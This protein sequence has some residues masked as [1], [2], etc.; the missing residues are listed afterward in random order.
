MISFDILRFLRHVWYS[1]TGKN[2]HVVCNAR[3]VLFNI[4]A[5]TGHFLFQIAARVSFVL[6]WILFFNFRK[7][8][9]QKPV[10]IVGNFRSGSSFLQRLM[11]LDRTNFTS[12]STWEIYF[13]PALLQK[14]FYK[15]VFT[16][17]RIIGSP[18]R[19]LISVIE[20]RSLGTVR[21]HKMGFAEPEEDEGVFAYTWDCLFLWLMFPYM[22]DVPPLHRFD[23][24]LPESKKRALMRFYERCV[25][26]HMLFRKTSRH[27]LSKSPAF[28]PKVQSLLK[29]F[30]DARFIYLVRTP[31]EVIP[32]I[33]NW[34]TLAWN[35]FVNPDERYPYREFVIEMTRHWYSYTVDFLKTLPEDQHI[36]MLYEDF[37]QDPEEAIRKIYGRFNIVISDDFSARLRIKTE[38]SRSYI[39]PN[40]LD[41]SQDGF[42]PEYILETFSDVFDQFGFDRRYTPHR[43][44]IE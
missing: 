44:N 41:L 21:I 15:A 16:I 3:R 7:K 39:S 1:I 4:F 34:F 25:N 19:R 24:D 10:F 35:F 17:D 13:A 9:A 2:P 32:S 31:Y 23:T 38:K 40:M 29:R 18:L 42:T 12:M 22:D 20:A 8:K 28:S 14:Y 11:N 33:M 27:Y 5:L 36:I 30:P 26:R 37:V 43:D 6:D